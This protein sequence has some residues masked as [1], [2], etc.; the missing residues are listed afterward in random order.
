MEPANQ[1]RP[2]G[3]RV[4]RKVNDLARGTP[5]A[6]E[7]TNRV[8]GTSQE[9]AELFEAGKTLSAEKEQEQRARKP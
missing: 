2:D 1:S 7:L 3:G 4:S 9:T 6:R 8:A 5:D